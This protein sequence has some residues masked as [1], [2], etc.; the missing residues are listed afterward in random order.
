M[1]LILDALRKSERTRQQSLTGQLGAGEVPTSLS[2]LPVPW[3]PLV[4]AL[5]LMNA[6]LL[7]FFWPHAASTPAIPTASTPAAPAAPY[8]PTVRPLASEIG[9]GDET[10]PVLPVPGPVSKV[11]PP[12]NPSLAA[13]MPAE[14]PPVRHY[15][16]QPAVQGIDS[17]PAD[18]RQALPALHLDVHAYAKDPAERFVVIN[19]QRYHIGD[20]LAEGP[21]LVD[22]LPQGAVLEF[23]GA[24][25]LLPAS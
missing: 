7:W 2:R 10:V 13:A 1:S 4:G 19:L 6:M 8:R 16:N 21:K 23:R 5:L 25:F 15:G 24:T 18:L 3:V 12:G 11:A 14:V 17:L 22:I 9:P 20:L